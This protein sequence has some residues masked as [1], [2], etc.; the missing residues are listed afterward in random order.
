MENNK[1][2]VD[3]AT[4][5]GAITQEIFIQGTKS[6]HVCIILLNT[7]YEAVGHKTL[8]E[9]SELNA[10]QKKEIVR[11]LAFADA[12]DHIEGIARWQKIVAEMVAE[13][14]SDTAMSE[15]PSE[16]LYDHL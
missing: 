11:N 7:G 13:R 16:P 9:D 3:Q 1:Y 5:D 2:K 12:T 6:T 8:P 4:V 15:A 14:Q 10:T